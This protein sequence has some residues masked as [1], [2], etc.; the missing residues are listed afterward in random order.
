MLLF[1]LPR[2]AEFRGGVGTGKEQLLNLFLLNQLA[3]SL[4][5]DSAPSILDRYLDKKK[6]SSLSIKMLQIFSLQ[7][8]FQPLMTAKG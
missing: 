8:R 2:D 4:G 6:I 5:K 3:V 7:N 1:F